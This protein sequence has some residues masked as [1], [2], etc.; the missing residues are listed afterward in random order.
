MIVFDLDGVIFE[1]DSFYEQMYDK[2]DEFAPKK[3][4]IEICDKYLKTDT[5]K[6]AELVIGKMWAGLSDKGYWE[7]IESMKF[8]P[9]VE[10]TIAELKKKG[11]K[12]MVLS[13]A[14]EDAVLK[15]VKILGIDYYICNKIKTKYGKITGKYEWNVMFNGKGKV[16]ADFCKEKGI[17]LKDVTAVGD[18]ENDLSMMEE[19][20]LSIAFNTKSEKLKNECKVLIEGN[21]LR[22]ILRYID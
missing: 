20:G 1:H 15:A 3:K 19:V 14:V 11:I 2:Y 16:L 9:G 10:E 4:I 6:A 18:N 12:I 22:D 21:D 13:S 17:D 7:I 5:L 8:N